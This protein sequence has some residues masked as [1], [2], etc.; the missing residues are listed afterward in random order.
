[1]DRSTTIRGAVLTALS[2]FKHKNTL[3]PIFDEIVNPNTT[4]PKIDG[5]EVYMVIQNQ[6]QYDGQHT[7]CNPRFNLNITLRIV[8]K[9]GLVGSKKLCEDIGDA[10]LALL[11]DDRGGSKL[12]GYQKVEMPVS[13]TMTEI[14][15]QNLAF[16]KIITL[17]FI[18]NG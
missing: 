6:Q 7:F 16:T 18:Q 14:T 12:A 10:V 11:R 3:V 15:N 2:G 8:T 17:N 4:I 13:R 5:A 1:M 9:W